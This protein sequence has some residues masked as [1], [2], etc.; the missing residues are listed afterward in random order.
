[1]V[2]KTVL[3]NDLNIF[4]NDFQKIYN[5]FGLKELLNK[6]STIFNVL[7]DFYFEYSQ[8]LVEIAD[9]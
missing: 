3:N 6:Y 9:E 5:E 2:K 1:M 7:K 8:Y 4:F